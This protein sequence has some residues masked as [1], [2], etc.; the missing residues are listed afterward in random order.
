M[1][2]Y[3]LEVAF[4]LGRANAI[5]EPIPIAQ[6]REHLFGIM[7]MNDWSA[8]DVQKWEYQPLGPFNAKNFLTTV[9]P[10]IVTLESLEPFMVEG[11]P[12]SGDDPENLEYLQWSDDFGIDLAL[13]VKISSEGMRADGTEPTTISQGNYAE[14]YW[15]MSQ[16]LAHHTSTGCPMRPGDL[17]ASGTVSGTTEDSRGCLLE[18][19]W[20]G[21]NPI[22][23][24]DGTERKFLQD[25]DEVV[26]T[27]CC[28][29]EGARRIGFGTCTGVIM[30]V[31]EPVT[32]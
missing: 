3:E 19:T 13:T 7:L 6:A 14:M 32:A 18:R 12:R 17:M 20:R 27:G 15:T 26:I 5:G 9:S 1:L 29:Q 10:W 23:L 25:G 22:T 28:E 4:V 30:P 16:M 24:G 31:R 11:P 21:A 2:D 8:R